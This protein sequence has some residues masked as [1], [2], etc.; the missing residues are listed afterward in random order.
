MMVS[1]KAA[2]KLAGHA[3][4]TP[5]SRREFMALVGHRAVRH[6]SVARIKAGRLPPVLIL[7][8]TGGVGKGLLASTLAAALFC[9]TGEGC[10]R[11]PGCQKVS[12]DD[13]PELLAFYNRQGEDPVRLANDDAKAIQEFIELRPSQI[14]QSA[15]LQQRLKDGGQALA[16][17][18]IV[19]DFDRFNSVAQ[20]RLLKTLEEPPSYLHFILTT[21][22]PEAILP[23]I[24]S[25]A[26]LERVNGLSGDE[27]AELLA[28]LRSAASSQQESDEDFL[29]LEQLL[30]RHPLPLGYALRL[31]KEYGSDFIRFLEDLGRGISEGSRMAGSDRVA[32]LK[33][34]KDSKIPVL[35]L[36]QFFEL[37]LNLGYRNQLANGH[38]RSAAVPVGRM[39]YRRAALAAVKAKVVP[40][41][42]GQ[43]VIET[44]LFGR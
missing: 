24:R 40:T 22:E 36:L 8:G 34:V 25:R 7:A 26:Q 17:V 23:T 21:S 10:G 39:L 30:S 32:L 42:N 20:N 33:R 35:V 13:H 5:A 15:A 18:V 37:E 38:G 12:A 2:A 14:G 11:C 1:R 16:K 19:E 41:T 9:D 6:R 44:L 43:L 4:G 3:A 28:Q 31:V 27:T 29:L